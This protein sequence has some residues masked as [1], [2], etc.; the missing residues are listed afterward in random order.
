MFL[1]LDEMRIQEGLEW[2]KHIDD[3]IGYVNLSNGELNSTALKK[4]DKA[5]STF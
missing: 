3:L 1:L 4:Q 2:D 5:A